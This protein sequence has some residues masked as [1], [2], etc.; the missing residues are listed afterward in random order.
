[1]R[2][3]PWITTLATVLLASACATT[4]PPPAKPRADIPVAEQKSADSVAPSLIARQQNADDER[5]ALEDAARAVEQ[6]SIQAELAQHQAELAQERA[7]EAVQEILEANEQAERESGT[8]LE[9]LEEDLAETRR[10]LA[11]HGDTAP[12]ELRD[13]E[14]ALQAR[15]DVLYVERDRAAK[16]QHEP[17][18]QARRAQPRRR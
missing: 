18:G 1:M 13:R 16:K 5:L 6:A 14:V 9:K 3:N 8:D 2:R 12:Q 11:A 15:I 7:S 4:A 10:E 17:R